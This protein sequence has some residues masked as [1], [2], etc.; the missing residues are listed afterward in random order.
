MA[1]R[2]TPDPQYN[3]FYDYNGDVY[4]NRG[5]HQFRVGADFRQ[6]TRSIHDGNNDGTYTFGN[7]Y[8]RQYDDGGPNGNYNPGTL[9]LSWA[10]FMTG[11]AHHRHH[12]EQRQLHGVQPVRRGLL[13]RTPG[14]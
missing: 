3:R 14:E 7:T 12:F 2:G 13:L 11:L 8:F 5:N 10:S 4:H 9:G 6:Q 1:S